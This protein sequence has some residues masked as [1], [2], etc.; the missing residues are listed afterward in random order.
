MVPADLVD[1]L[2]KQRIEQ[3]LGGVFGRLLSTSE[4]AAQAAEAQA[5][6]QKSDNLIKGL[7]LEV[8]K[9]A[10]REEELRT[11]KE[12][13]FSFVT[14]VCAHD[15]AYESDLGEIDLD[16]EVTHDFMDE[17]QTARSQRLF[18]LLCSVLKGRPLLL[19]RSLESSRCGFEAVRLLRREMEHREKARSLALMRQL[20]A[21]T[22]PAMRLYEEAA[23]QPFPK[24]LV[25]A[26]VVTGL[27]DPLKSQVQLRMTETTTYAEI[28]EWVLQFE[29]LNAPWSSSLPSGKGASQSGGGPQ[30]MDVDMVKGK[31]G[32]NKGKNGKSKGKDGKNKGETKDG[33]GKDAKPWTWPGQNPG[34]GWG[35]S[36]QGQG[37]KQPWTSSGKDQQKGK[38][39]GK[40]V[41]G[42]CAICGDMGHWKNECPK[43]QGRVNQVE[44]QSTAGKAQ[45]QAQQLL[46]R[47]P[48]HFEPSR[49]TA[50]TSSP[51]TAARG[52]SSTGK[53][54]ATPL[55]FEP[56]WS[57]GS[58]RQ[59][60]ATSTSTP[61]S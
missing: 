51:P 53:R 9:P 52:T 5:N 30:P 7:K 47:R 50:S 3:A 8:F 41:D 14:Y 43:G 16:V 56:V 23:G 57:R 44:T 28:R 59:S 58:R 15:P 61:G 54:R 60:R 19:I 10:T 21:W 4:R 1:R 49:P 24:E 48:R 29:S 36:W 20:A 11:W 12:W 39:R 27:R 35:A 6:L 55:P 26:T 2:V 38:L 13:W 22:F 33:K 45:P 31:H 40:G 34:K 42:G 46:R 37:W 32:K 17:Q 25:L 18:G